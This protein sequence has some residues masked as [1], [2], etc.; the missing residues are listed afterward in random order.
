MHGRE[1]QC[2]EN[3]GLHVV[4]V[5]SARKR[6]GCIRWYGNPAIPFARLTTSATGWYSAPAARWCLCG[7]RG[8]SCVG[9]AVRRRTST[10]TGSA[11]TTLAARAATPACAPAAFAR[12]APGRRG[13]RARGGWCIRSGTHGID[14]HVT[15]GL[16][17]VHLHHA[18]VVVGHGSEIA[19]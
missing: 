2:G 13:I 15:A 11:P 10:T 17:L 9:A 6:V 14:V 12:A 7:S 8:A 3:A 5:V 4:R 18:V 16:R 1:L 19:G